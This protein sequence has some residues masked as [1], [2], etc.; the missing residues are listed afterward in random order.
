MNNQSSNSEPNFIII[1]LLLVVSPMLFV[2]RFTEDVFPLNPLIDTVLPEEFSEDKFYSIREGMS[3]EE[4]FKLLGK[5]NGVYGNKW[6]D[7]DWYYGHDGGC[8]W[9]DFAWFEYEI[10]FDRHDRVIKT[11]RYA[12]AS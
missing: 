5:P 4:V 3:K 6:E 2:L 1:L 11:E 10:I 7:E 8:K 12:I 9:W